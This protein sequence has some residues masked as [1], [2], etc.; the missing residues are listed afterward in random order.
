[1][2]T[3]K[4]A[5]CRVLI[6]AN[7]KGGVAKSASAVNLSAALALNG[8]KVLM[9]DADSQGTGSNMFG[10]DDV[11]SL[12]I[13]LATVLGKII[14]DEDVDPSEGII[15]NAEGVDILPSNIDLAALEASLVNVMNRERLF[16]TY[17]DIVKDNYDYIIVDCLPSLGM[18]TI[19]ALACADSVLIP[20]QAE[21]P[22]AK[23][24]VQLLKSIIKVKKHINPALEI[25][26]I[27]PTMV[28]GRLNYSKDVIKMIEDSYGSQIHIFE[29]YIPRLAKMA[30]CAAVGESIFSYE[31][32][33]PAAEAY[34]N[35][36]KEVIENGTC[37]E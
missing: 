4:R 1:M 28:D 9:I 37:S 22:A 34:M 16:K 3:A 35:L 8:K 14:N 29:H 18:I 20:V 10:I 33:C 7:Q 19:N 32:S 30:E 13:T 11:D 25:E 21:K 2:N 12:E 17:V 6:I 26:G 36:A 15:K 5:N 31:P 23:G 27:L 24:L